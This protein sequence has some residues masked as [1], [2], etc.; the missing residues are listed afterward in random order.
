MVVPI[1]N[2][3]GMPEDGFVLSAVFPRDVKTMRYEAKNAFEDYAP[4]VPQQMMGGDMFG[5]AFG[6]MG[7]AAPLAVQSVG[8][9]QISVA[10]SLHDLE[11]RAPWSCFPSSIGRVDGILADMRAHY[12]SG[13]AFVV[14]QSTLPVKEAGFSVVY[15]DADP[16]VPTAHEIVGAAWQC[17]VARP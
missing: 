16:F 6:G 2:K 15:Q 4:M 14:A 10:P 11:T 1:P 9:Y 13:Y 12:G 8:A 17:H 7:G 5:A 3:H